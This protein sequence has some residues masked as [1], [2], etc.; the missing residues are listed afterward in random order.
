M[1]NIKQFL[2]LLTVISQLLG[3]VMLFINIKMAILIYVIYGV[4]FIII[5]II[6]INERQKDKEEENRDDY[7]N[8]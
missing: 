8:Y 6:L 2:L 1:G 5:I 7:R 4:L 3:I